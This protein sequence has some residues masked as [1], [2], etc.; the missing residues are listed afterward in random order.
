M[1]AVPDGFPKL[2]KA[3]RPWVC[4][5]GI[6]ACT[7]TKPCHSCRGRRNR[8]R[9]RVKQRVGVK[10]IEQQFDISFGDFR[11]Q[12]AHEENMRGSIRLEAKSGAQCGPAA[13]RF[14]KSEEQSEA[15]RPVGDLRPF[16]EILMPEG[17]GNDG[18]FS[19]RLSQLGRVVEALVNQ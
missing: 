19:C 13:T 14:K 1:T 7:R 15:A 16:A 2:D 11:G 6:A 5:M 12:R 8:D 9:G 18:I 3:T 4:R 17:W 10:L